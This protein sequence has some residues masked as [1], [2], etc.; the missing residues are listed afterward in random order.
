MHSSIKIDLNFAEGSLS[1]NSDRRLLEQV[2]VNFIT[3]ALHAVL[4][5]GGDNGRIE[6]RTMK[7]NSEVEISVQDNGVGIPEKDQ[8]NI[9]E[10]FYTTKP[11]GK[12]TGLGLPICQSIV[13]QLGG[14]ITFESEVGVGTIFTVRIPVS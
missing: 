9:F 12:G 10:L 4:E 6:I 13:R 5:K 1:V 14:N 3:N 11:P 2:F 8:G 7:T